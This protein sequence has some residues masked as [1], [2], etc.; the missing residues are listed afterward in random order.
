MISTIVIFS[1]IN[2]I[3][4]Y[5]DS[6]KILNSKSIKHGIN[7]LFYLS[8]ILVPFLIFGNYFLITCLLFNRLVFFNIS[9]SLFRKLKWDY[10]PTDPASIID[11]ISKSIFGVNG[12]I[13][14]FTYS[15]L[16]IIFVVFSFLF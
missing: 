10:I 2:I 16:F 11:K 9:L 5:I 4:A 8:M 14:Y 7:A 13:M 1:L 15:L 3:L 6:H 12:K